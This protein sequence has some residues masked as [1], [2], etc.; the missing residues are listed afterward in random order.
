M[1]T[2]PAPGLDLAALHRIRAP[3]ARTD[4]TA[5]ADITALLEAH[6][7]AHDGYVAL[8]R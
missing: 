6:L 5:L 2:T 7:A 8:R 1:T 3:S 4:A